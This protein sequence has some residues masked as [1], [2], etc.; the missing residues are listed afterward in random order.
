MDIILV[1]RNTKERN[2]CIVGY[3]YV[4]PVV[5]VTVEDKDTI[6]VSGMDNL[7]GFREVSTS[8]VDTFKLILKSIPPPPPSLPS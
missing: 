2:V 8:K 7:V 6:Q 1:L 4:P 5:L 3:I